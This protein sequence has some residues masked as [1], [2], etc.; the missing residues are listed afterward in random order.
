MSVTQQ[1]I[2][3]IK[4]MI[5]RGELRSGDRLPKEADLAARLGLSRNSLREA[6]RALTM[7]RILETRQGDGTYVTSLEPDI[8][9]ETVSFI[10]DYHRDRTL[11]HVLEVRRILETAA[12]GLAAQHIS[13]EQ[14]AELEESVGQMDACET[15]E[16]FVDNDL[17]FHRTIAGASG[18]PVLA[19]LLESLSSRT[20]RARVWRGVTQAGAIEQ[21]KA[22]HRAI[23]EALARHRPELASGLAIAHLAGVESW[24]ERTL[25]EAEAEEPAA[26]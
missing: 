20:S 13:D 5:I 1:A 15:V 4:A 19:S 2:D 6:V 26:A 17:A 21:T 16:A 12:T 23:Y 14:L 24:L 18:N 25:E 3:E 9:L 22:D 10:A 8:L 11:L 7:V